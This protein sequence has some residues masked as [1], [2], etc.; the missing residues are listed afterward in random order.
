MPLITLEAW[1][2]R[3]FEQPPHIRTAR[4]WIREA[5]ISPTPVKH[6]RSYYLE[7][8]AHYAPGEVTQIDNQTATL[9]RTTLRSRIN[10][11]TQNSRPARAS[12]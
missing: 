11:Q 4:R 6:G 7:A 1:L 12:R 8:D 10:G 5:R 9:D 2:T 3:T